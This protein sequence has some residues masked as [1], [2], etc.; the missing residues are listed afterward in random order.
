MFES[1]LSS[2][3]SALHRGAFYLSFG[4]SHILPFIPNPMISPQS[5]EG[6]LANK[7]TPSNGGPYRQFHVDEYLLAED[8]SILRLPGMDFA[9]I[10]TVSWCKNKNGVLHEF[11]LV[12]VAAKSGS[13]YYPRTSA[14]L[15]ERLFNQNNRNA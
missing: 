11:L 1:E 3:R 2:I 4:L 9:I 13:G 12:D 5:Q 7:C 14:I 10:T 8:S 6:F 15:L